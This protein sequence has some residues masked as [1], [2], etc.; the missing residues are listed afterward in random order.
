MSLFSVMSCI[1]SIVSVTVLNFSLDHI[2]DEV[3]GLAQLSNIHSAIILNL[4]NV[5]VLLVV[6]RH[7]SSR[8]TRPGTSNVLQNASAR[9]NLKRSALRILD[10]LG[11]PVKI[12][13]S[14][15]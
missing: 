8:A 7:I 3:L 14:H 15:I 11:A 4:A 9:I 6:I 1:R 10:L 5:L 12:L 13:F 2:R